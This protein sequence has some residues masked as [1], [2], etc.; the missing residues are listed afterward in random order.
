[1]K[2]LLILCVLLSSLTLANPI[3]NDVVIGGYI[4]SYYGFD[5]NEPTS[6]RQ[7][8]TQALRSNEFNI[9]LAYIEAKLQKEK[10]HGRLALQAGTSVYANYS[11]ESRY[12]S[13]SQLA[14]VM[15]H[16]QE[17]YAGYQVTKNLWIDTGI[18]FSH[19]GSEGFISK[20][21]W[22]Y[23]RS[24]AADYSPYY[25][26]GVRALYTIN[27]NWSA[28]L[29]VM[30]GWQNMI[31]TNTDKAIGMQISYAPTDKF[32]VTYN[33]FI[34]RESGLR[35]FNDLIFK[36]Q[37]S[38]DLSLC[39]TS[40]FGLQKKQ[41]ID[42]YSNWFNETLTG[43][44]A[45]SEKLFLGTRLEYFQ[46]KDQVLI[47]TNT[48]NGFQ[49]YGASLNLDW[50][51]EPGLLFRNELRY[52]LSRDAVFNSKDGSNTGNTLAITSVSLSL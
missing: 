16:V 8:T 39:L 47:T 50:E 3:T 41:G 48:S 19:I 15:R 37:V 43:R 51:L 22:N 33:N 42:D 21:N 45:L 13:G 9:N 11:G 7:Y 29:Q 32:S 44:L 30:N 31:E 26:A 27:P 24:L 25:Q 2:K 38:K 14:D 10:V 5:F 49:T 23:T 40:D 35:I 36:L 20:D 52:L 1:M 46:D 17:A 6:D 34:G 18:F 4:D 28:Q 12:G